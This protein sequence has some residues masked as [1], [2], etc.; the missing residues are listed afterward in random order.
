MD[1]EEIGVLRQVWLREPHTQKLKKESGLQKKSAFSYLM[2][3]CSKSTD[4][5]VIKAKARYDELGTRMDMFE[6]G[7]V[8][9]D[10]RSKK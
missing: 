4:P 10:H 6:T 2:S 8:T 5:A 9:P 1:D 3:A 7:Q